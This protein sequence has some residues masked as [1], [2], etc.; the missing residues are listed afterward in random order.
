[1]RLVEL[2]QL[3]DGQ[4]ASSGGAEEEAEVEEGEG[5][6]QESEMDVDVVAPANPSQASREGA[7]YTFDSPPPTQGRPLSSASR[8]GGGFVFETP[9]TQEPSGPSGARAME[10]GESDE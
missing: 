5:G 9:S 10:D 6:S 4:G 7:G 2:M 1:V 8:E 3:L